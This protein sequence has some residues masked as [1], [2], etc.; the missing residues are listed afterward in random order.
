MEIDDK[1]TIAKLMDKINISKTRN[2]IVN[3]EFLTTNQKEIIKRELKKINLKNYIFFGGYEGAEAESLIIYPEK[4]EKEIIEKAIKEIIKV[5]EIILPKSKEL[6]G[7]YTHRDYLGVLIKSGLNRN[8][9]GDIVVHEDSSYIIVLNENVKYITEYLKELT[10]FNKAVINVINY[11]KIK[12]KEQEFEEIKI[13]VSSIRLD[14][15]ISQIIKTSRQKAVKMI[16]EEKVFINSK[17][18][19]KRTKEVKQKD[20]LAIRGKGKYIIN[21]ISEAGKKGKIIVILKKYK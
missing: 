9:I 13:T 15:I 21:E 19:T 7:K 1:L 2:K 4:F 5:I 20:V 11:D 18:E 17:V 8:R 16:L 12:L 10:I 3:T 14:S 6:L